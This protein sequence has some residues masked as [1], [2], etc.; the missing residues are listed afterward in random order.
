[1]PPPGPAAL[2]Q[3]NQGPSITVYPADLFTSTN[4]PNPNVTGGGSGVTAKP[5]SVQ[6]DASGGFY[7]QIQLVAASQV[8]TGFASGAPG[9]TGSSGI[10]NPVPSTTTTAT[11]GTSVYLPL[12]WKIND[13]EV[14]AW[15]DTTF[16]DHVP[17]I[18]EIAK[19][20]ALGL[21][22]S[23]SGVTINPF[24]YMMY[25]QPAFRE[26]E[27]AWSF[28]PNNTTETQTLCQIINYLKTG[29][30]PEY[31]AGGYALALPYIALVRINPN[32]YMFDFKPCAITS[33]NIDFTGSGHGPAFYNDG[34]PAI[35]SFTLGLKEVEIQVRSDVAWRGGA[36]TTDMTMSPGTLSGTA[37]SIID[38]ITNTVKSTFGTIT[39]AGT[40]GGTGTTP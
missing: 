26:F 34:G 27:L 4:T 18:N 8:L 20:L 23:G 19:A 36:L 13:I 28:S 15:N 7:T 22:A 21:R 31:A 35:I 14:H 2:S 24:Q 9:V 3:T 12:P 6:T 1:M 5:G 11:T 33:V 29:A 17:V 39:S 37:G 32:K 25:K 10:A 40:T 16:Y 38:S 30:L